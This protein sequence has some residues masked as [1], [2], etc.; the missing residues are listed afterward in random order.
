MFIDQH[1]HPIRGFHPRAN[2]ERSMNLNSSWLVYDV[3][4]TRNVKYSF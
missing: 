2:T 1:P 3:E 4:F